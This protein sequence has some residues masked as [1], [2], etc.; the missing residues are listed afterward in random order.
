MAASPQGR[1][2][3]TAA[4]NAGLTGT[5]F[6]GHVKHFASVGS[7][8]TLAM[9]AAQ[10]GARA[11]VWV[12]D[13][14]TAGRGRGGHA[15]HSAARDGLY[16]SAIVVPRVPVARALWI[17]LAT[18][19]AVRAAILETTAL[20]ADIRWPNDL[21]LGGRKCA[22]ILVE[23]SIAAARE[24][25]EATMRYVV[26]GMGINVLHEGFPVELRAAAT[27][28]RLETGSEI[29]RQ[30]LLLHLLRALDEELTKL[31]AQHVATATGEGG[32]LERF[33][34]ASTWVRGKQVRVGETGGYTG[35][36]AGLSSE[37][38]LRVDANDGTE[39]TVLSGGVRELI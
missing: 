27:S 3:N 19:L 33:A 39:R 14:Q 32:L 10:R 1:E 38:F 25:V 16:V 26:I 29:S 31:D 37:G 35:V 13:E 12:A 6:A 8:N 18:A 17:S 15:W 20:T 11:G 34:A 36:T 21:L 5:R 30:K 9:E 2:L 24:Q 22:G 4:L 28:L 7:T 23:S